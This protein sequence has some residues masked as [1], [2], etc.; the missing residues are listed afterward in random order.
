MSEWQPIASAPK[1]TRL[2]LWSTEFTQVIGR[3]HRDQW[4]DDDGRRIDDFGA[5]TLWQHLPESPA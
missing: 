2:L 5:I 3:W 1:H 4:Q